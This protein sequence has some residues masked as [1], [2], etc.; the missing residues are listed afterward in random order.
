MA[1][2]RFLQGIFLKLDGEAIED[3][4]GLTTGAITALPALIGSAGVQFNTG[5][6]FSR[7]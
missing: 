6:F 4:E 5:V 7:T 1:Q 3:F 2:V